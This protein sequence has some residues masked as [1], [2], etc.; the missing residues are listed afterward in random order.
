[1]FGLVSD[2]H[3]LGKL[4]AVQAERILVEGEKPEDLPV[5]RLSRFKFWINIDV[6]SELG[7]YPPMDLISI[8]DFK[9]SNVN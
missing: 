8:A 5:A 2:Y 1:M 9:Q 6:A 3:T 4:A 7:L